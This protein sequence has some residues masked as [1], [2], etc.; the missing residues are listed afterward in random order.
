MHF[1]DYIN[2]QVLNSRHSKNNG[3]R[4]IDNSMLNESLLLRFIQLHH[5]LQNHNYIHVTVIENNADSR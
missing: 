1:S 3:L 5:P 2:I 4:M